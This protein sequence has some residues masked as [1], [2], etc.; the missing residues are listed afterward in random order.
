MH[1]YFN[2]LTEGSLSLVT[3][4]SN[5]MNAVLLKVGKYHPHCHND[6][7][8][9]TICIWPTQ[10]I[11]RALFQELYESPL[12]FFKSIQN[13]DFYP[14]YYTSICKQSS[15]NNP[16]RRTKAWATYFPSF[17]KCNGTFCGVYRGY[18]RRLRR[19]SFNNLD[20]L[21]ARQVVA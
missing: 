12:L 3:V 6:I 10:K 15:I 16:Q 5:W 17:C 2:G 11:Y 7:K 1:A 13:P 18:Y 8:K 20:H 4:I 19:S 21:D 9:Y 14:S